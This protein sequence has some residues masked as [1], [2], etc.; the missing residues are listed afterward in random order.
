[1]EL[2]DEAKTHLAK[3]LE[4]VARGGRIAIT[5]QGKPVAEL[6][7]IADSSNE[8]LRTALGKLDQSR[9]RQRARRVQVTKENILSAI[10]E[11]RR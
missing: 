3:L 7:P 10:R 5:R 1:M 8:D 6:R 2:G 9:A 11:G 4:R